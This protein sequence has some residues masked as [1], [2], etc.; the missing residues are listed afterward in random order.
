MVATFVDPVM[1]DEQRRLACFQGSLILNSPTPITEAYCAFAAATHRRCVRGRIPSVPV[2][3]PVDGVRGDPR[4][5]ETALH[6]PPG[7]EVVPARDPARHAGCDLDRTHFDVP[8][9]RK[10]DERRLPDVGCRLRPSPPPRH[11]VLGA[12]PAVQLVAAGLPD[13]GLQLDGVPSAVLRTEV[14]NS[15]STTTT[16]GTPSTARR[17][18]P[19]SRPKR[20]PCPGRRWT[21][22]CRSRSCRCPAVGGLIEFSGQHM[23]S[24]V[25]NQTGRTRFSIDFRTMHVDDVIGGRAAPNVDARCTGSSIRDFLRAS[26]FA[27][28]PDEVVEH[29]A[30]GTEGPRRLGVL[31]KLTAGSFAARPNLVTLLL[32]IE[33]VGDQ[34]AV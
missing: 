26:D 14:Q 9:L 23:H 10:V 11:V 5:P 22:T 19:T 30:D 2:D 7:V 16:S 8:R 13:R 25:P 6:P 21:S 1:T 24:S 15:S 31:E 29:F 4:R 34:I 27:P 32:D 17:R 20:D 12:L 3:L 18:R 28:V 33:N